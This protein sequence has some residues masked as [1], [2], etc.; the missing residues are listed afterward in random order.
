MA[1]LGRFEFIIGKSQPKIQTYP[2]VNAPRPTPPP[3]PFLHV[4]YIVVSTYYVAQKNLSEN[5]VFCISCSRARMLLVAKYLVREGVR[6]RCVW[7]VYGRRFTIEF[8]KSA[9]I[10][11][12][13]TPENTRIVPSKCRNSSFR[14]AKNPTPLY[15]VRVLRHTKTNLSENIVFRVDLYKEVCDRKRL[16]C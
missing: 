13:A 4:R 16:I 5:I 10:C 11:G 15:N 3:P 7:E 12:D 2:G 8:H 6:Q 14:D 9:K 1:R